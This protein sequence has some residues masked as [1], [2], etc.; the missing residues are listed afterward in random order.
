MCS[1]AFW[2]VNTTFYT[3][4]LSCRHLKSE[5]IAQVHKSQNND[6]RKEST[7]Q[8]NQCTS[9]TCSSLNQINCPVKEE[10]HSAAA[11]GAAVKELDFSVETPFKDSLSHPSSCQN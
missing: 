3:S 2:T 6:N 4:F 11:V 9:L 1:S 5:F 7:E 8:C 10:A